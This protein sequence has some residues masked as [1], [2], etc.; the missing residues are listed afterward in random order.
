[1]RTREDLSNSGFGG[2]STCKVID[3]TKF[4]RMNGYCYIHAKELVDAE[5]WA[6]W[7]L[8]HCKVSGCTA[9]IVLRQHCEQHGRRELGD[10]RFDILLRARQCKETGCHSKPM[11]EGYCAAHAHLR[12]GPGNDDK[13]VMTESKKTEGCKEPGCHKTRSI[14]SMC[15]VH[16]RQNLDPGTFESL[17]RA[18]KACREPGCQRRYAMKTYC[19]SHA[20]Q[21]LEPHVF[22]HLDR[23]FKVCKHFGCRKQVGARGRDGFCEMH[24]PSG[25]VMANTSPGD[26]ADATMSWDV[27]MVSP[28][29]AGAVH[30]APAPPSRRVK[31]RKLCVHEGCSKQAQWPSDSCRAHDGGRRCEG[32]VMANTSPGDHANATMSGETTD[33]RTGSSDSDDHSTVATSSKSI[34]APMDTSNSDEHPNEKQK[35]EE[36]EVRGP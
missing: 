5:T 35:N 12:L 32:A 2:M 29:Q 34:R 6:S 31:K 4:R 14:K 26:H 8:R 1:M 28:E 9:K 20:R 11:K 33:I 10:E 22:E 23:V 7:K 30:P 25:A 16:A 21:R 3:C 19:R 13:V 17:Y 24:I 36:E 27:E 18:I 15:V